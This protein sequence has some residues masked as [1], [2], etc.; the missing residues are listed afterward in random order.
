MMETTGLVE[1][2]MEKFSSTTVS[3]FSTLVLAIEKETSL[4]SSE[5]LQTI[6]NRRKCYTRSWSTIKSE[7]MIPYSQ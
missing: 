6:E 3:F 2:L 4:D 7:M 1:A 5:S